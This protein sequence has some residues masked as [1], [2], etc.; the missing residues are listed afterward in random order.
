MWRIAK[1][2]YL[3][4]AWDFQDGELLFEAG[5]THILNC[6]DDAP[7]WLRRR[8]RYRHLPLV[9]PDP[10]FQDRIE[11]FCKFIH[12][13]RRCGGVLVHCDDSLS[14]SLAVAPVYLCWRG[15]PFEKA[16]AM[17]RRRVEEMDDGLVTLDPCFRIYRTRLEL[18]P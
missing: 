14:R 11:W 9:D 4:D 3:G 5:I 8:F 15:K 13:G 7:G 6:A 2:L 1:G 16:L 17:L 18:E 10:T 12:R